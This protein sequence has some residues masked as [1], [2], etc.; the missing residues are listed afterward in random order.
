M[1]RKDYNRLA[2]A[3]HKTRREIRHDPGL[4][5]RQ[6]FDMYVAVCMVVGNLADALETENYRF[7]R[8]KFAEA[9]RVAGTDGAAR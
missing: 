5:E 4:S 9:C 3:I 6:S 7:D 2:A 1:T 8:D